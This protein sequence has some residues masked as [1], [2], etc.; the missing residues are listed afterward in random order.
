MV[1]DSSSHDSATT[2][3]DGDG[4]ILG[5]TQGKRRDATWPVAWVCDYAVAIVVV[6]K[7]I[8][9]LSLVAYISRCWT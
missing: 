8:P 2:E 6:C 5:E 9:T 3:N 4:E 7:D 1:A